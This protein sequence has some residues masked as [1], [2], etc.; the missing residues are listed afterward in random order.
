MGSEAKTDIKNHEKD[1]KP[2]FDGPLDK[3]SYE[4]DIEVDTTFEICYHG[5]KDTVL[6]IIRFF[7]EKLILTLFFNLLI[8]VVSTFYFFQYYLISFKLNYIYYTHLN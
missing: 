1:I 5:N 2:D 7:D 6:W 3:N 8:S 4:N